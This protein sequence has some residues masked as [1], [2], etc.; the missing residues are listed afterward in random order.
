[1]QSSLI[2]SLESELSLLQERHQTLVFLSPQ[3][4]LEKQELACALYEDARYRESSDLFAEMCLSD[5]FKKVFWEGLALSWQKQSRFE[6][7]LRIWHIV[8]LL[9]KQDLSLHQKTHSLSFRGTELL[10]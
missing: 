9:N 6:E 2:S 5:P 7:A 1:M 4:L 10:I 8:D 3:E